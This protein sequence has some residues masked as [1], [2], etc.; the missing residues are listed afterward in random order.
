VV[1]ERPG[2]WVKTVVS[3]CLHADAAQANKKACQKNPSLR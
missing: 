1:D 2:Q 3:L